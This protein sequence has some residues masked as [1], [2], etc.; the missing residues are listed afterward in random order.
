M[1]DTEGFRQLSWDE[2][3]AMHRRAQEAGSPVEDAVFTVE[4]PDEEPPE[5]QVWDETYP[6]RAEDARRYLEFQEESHHVYWYRDVRDGRQYGMPDLETVRRA[7]R[8]FERRAEADRKRWTYALRW[9]G[10][11]FVLSIGL[12]GAVGPVAVWSWFALP[13]LALWFGRKRRLASGVDYLK[14]T[15]AR[16]DEFTSDAEREEL[17]RDAIRAGA[18]VGGIVAYKIIKRHLH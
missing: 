2:V 6:H 9:V 1:T 3:M 7:N 16:F 17:R 4:E 11:Y 8:R 10:I 12:I 18:V 13:F 15:E 5:W 14:L